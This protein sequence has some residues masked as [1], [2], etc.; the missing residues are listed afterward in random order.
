MSDSRSR[1]IH[2]LFVCSGNIC[3]SPMAEA[4][5][6]HR[7][8]QA[9]L[10][11][12]FEIASAGTGDWHVGEPPHPGTRDALRRH[13]VPAISGKRAQ[14]VSPVLLARADY[15]IAMDDSHVLDLREYGRAADGNVSRLLDYAPGQ[16]VRNVPD[17]Y[18]SG[19]YEEVYHLVEAGARGLLEHIRQKEGL[20][21]NDE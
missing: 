4:V 20:G 18:Y 10:T 17:P 15:V 9:G 8:A 14:R 13:A 6:A 19:R 1:R 12:R 7:V 11:E 21:T 5:F 3:R 16:P 2:V